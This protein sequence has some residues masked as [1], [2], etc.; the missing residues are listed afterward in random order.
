MSRW[1]DILADLR[2]KRAFAASMGGP[3]KLERH[4][5]AGKLDARQRAAALF[6]AGSFV[7]LGALAGNLSETSDTPAPADHH[8]YLPVQRKNVRTRHRS[9]LTGFG[10]S[11]DAGRRHVPR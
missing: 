1:D 4:R 10:T 7:E 6:D 11:L 2:Q 3:A 8:R 9:I 5:G